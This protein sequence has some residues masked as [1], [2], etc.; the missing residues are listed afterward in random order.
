MKVKRVLVNGVIRSVPDG[1]VVVETPKAPK[2][3]VKKKAA[4]K[5]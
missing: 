2:A 3:A 4:K 5:K 1:P